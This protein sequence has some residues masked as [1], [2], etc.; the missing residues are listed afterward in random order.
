LL[1]VP[2]FLVILT[3]L[4]QPQLAGDVALVCFAVF[5]RRALR[6]KTLCQRARP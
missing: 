2:G 4:M 3:V 6:S 5:W 1:R